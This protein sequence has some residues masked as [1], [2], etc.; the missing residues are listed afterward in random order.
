MITKA[1]L[2]GEGRFT[3]KSAVILPDGVTAEDLV[4]AL[5]QGDAKVQGQKIVHSDKFEAA[6]ASTDFDSPPIAWT[7][8]SVVTEEDPPAQHHSCDCCG[9]HSP[10]DKLRRQ[11]TML[12]N[13]AF[14]FV[15]K[16]DARTARKFVST[17]SALL[18][19]L[20][21]GDSE[22]GLWVLS[23]KAFICNVEGRHASAVR[24]MERAVNMARAVHGEAHQTFALTMNNAGEVLFEAGKYAKGEKYLLCGIGILNKAIDEKSVDLEWAKNAREDALT[25]LG[26]LYKATG[27]AEEGEALSD[28]MRTKSA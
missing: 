9:T 16:K 2:V 22:E 17:A 25:Q 28:A 15:Q 19:M 4:T 14:E 20:P 13:S 23:M 6:I 8:D 18:D 1:L 11:I 12:N 26:R 24:Y 5:N 21:A 10:E 3:R 27:R 7:L